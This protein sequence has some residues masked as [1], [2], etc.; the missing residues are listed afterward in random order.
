MCVILLLYFRGIKVV[1]FASYFKTY[2][3]NSQ[4]VKETV[5]ILI[6]K[7]EN[8]RHIFYLKLKHQFL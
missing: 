2:K 1:F 5:D 6:I 4:K 7:D 3:K 8:E